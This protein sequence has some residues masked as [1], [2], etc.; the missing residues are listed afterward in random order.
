MI[1]VV[2]ILIY[3]VNILLIIWFVIINFNI[4]YFLIKVRISSLKYNICFFFDSLYFGVDLD[5]SYFG[6]LDSDLDKFCLISS[7]R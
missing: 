2:I 4:I 7:S 3:L 5:C 6:N 1:F